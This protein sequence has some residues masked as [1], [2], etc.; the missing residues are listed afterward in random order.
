MHLAIFFY[1]SW[2]LGVFFCFL[3]LAFSHV[4]LDQPSSL[5]YY[6]TVIIS[7]EAPYNFASYWL[8]FFT[9]PF[10]VTAQI[11]PTQNSWIDNF[12]ICYPPANFTKLP[13]QNLFNHFKG[14]LF[15]TFSGFP[16][17]RFRP[18]PLS[19]F[20]QLGVAQLSSPPVAHGHKWL[21]ISVS[22]YPIWLKY[23]VKYI[24]TQLQKNI[25]ECCACC[26]NPAK[27]KLKAG[28]LYYWF[29]YPPHTK[30]YNLSSR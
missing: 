17:T 13:Q 10:I 2:V 18:P 16:P 7:C 19:N 4:R 15:E 27:L 8:T 6:L 11:N 26:H 23:C 1:G 3:R 12:I 24:W 20:D 21:N 25:L 28:M 22:F 9:L 14:I 29:L 5:E 30:K